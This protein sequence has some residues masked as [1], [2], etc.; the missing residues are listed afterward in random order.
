MNKKAIRCQKTASIL[1]TIFLSACSVLPFENNASIPTP[2]TNKPENI[3][4]G[5]E[6]YDLGIIGA[7]EPAYILPT[8]TPMLARIDT[9][10]ETSSIDAKNIKPFERDGKRWV[11]FDIFDEKT[12]TLH[13]FKKKVKRRISIKRAGKNESR[14]AVKM[15]ILFGGKVISEEFTL[16]DRSEFDYPLLIGRNILTGRAI[17]DTS[18]SHT[19]Y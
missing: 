10:A 16:T 5:S 9:G 6:K 1:L 11:S 3:F 13:P 18:I 14:Y 7:V 12:K 19:F 4:K 2:P 8:Q 15:D 17:V